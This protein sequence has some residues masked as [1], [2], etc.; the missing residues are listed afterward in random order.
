MVLL[1]GLVEFSVINAQEVEVGSVPYKTDTT[2]K[3][4]S[5]FKIKKILLQCGRPVGS[6]PS[7]RSARISCSKELFFYSLRPGHKLET[8]LYWFFLKVD[9]NVACV[10]V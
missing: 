4:G 7:V 1:C 8:D 6:P 9:L 10:N 2:L 3:G 5:Y